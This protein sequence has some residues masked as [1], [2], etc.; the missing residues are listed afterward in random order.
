MAACARGVDDGAPE[1]TPGVVVDSADASDSAPTADA[2]ADSALPVPAKMADRIGVYAWGFDDRAFGGFADRLTWAADRV[3]QLGSRTIRVYVGP[4]DVYRLGNL[5][6]PG[7]FSLFDAAKSP[8]YAA[9]FANPAFD[10]YVLTAYSK[11]DDAG[12]WKSGY[13]PDAAAAER[14][15][16]S[17]FGA[18]LL[19]TYPTKTFILL[20]W[21]G[22][23]AIAPYASNPAAWDGF[24]A[25]TQARA[26]GVKDA[27]VAAGGAARLFAGVEFNKVLG[28]DDKNKCVMSA[29]LPNV[30]VD[31][32]SYS[33]WAS[34][35]EDVDTGAVAARLQADL[36]KALGFARKKDK[37]RFLVG[38]FGAQREAST[39]GECTAAKRIAA[40]VSGL[41]AWG[42]GYGVFWQII[43]N[44]PTDVGIPQLGYGAFK[45]DQ[46][47][48]LA[49][50]VLRA[51]YTTETPTVPGAACP[52]INQGGVVD[53]QTY[54]T[55][56]HPGGV[57][58]IFGGGFSSNA[59]VHVVQK[60]QTL[61]VSDGTPWFYRSDKQINF[62]L[63]SSIVANDKVLVFVRNGTATDSNGQYPDVTP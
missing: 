11:D 60:T 37:S 48:T 25:W 10:T 18:H 40:I 55:P 38:E 26:D 23:N 6:S 14:K 53:G 3:R 39:F 21:E 58:S 4:S 43:D 13:P 8:A 59:E 31:Y 52:A 27:R 32:V 44:A 51:L 28:C 12:L 19:A 17:E 7:A 41:T 22:D 49:G 16:I 30:D 33:S 36:D 63:P 24:V 35:G 47:S 42:A 54:K 29:V 5:G 57:L 45:A 20:N 15:A 46:S 34:I 1:D 62:T 2:G 9:L 50:E 61:V 56:V